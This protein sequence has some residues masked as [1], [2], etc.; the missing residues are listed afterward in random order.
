MLK[1]W[2][3]EK[4]TAL[5]IWWGLDE[6]V[7]SRCHDV[8]IPSRNGTTQIDHLLM[9]RY[10]LFI[11]ET[12]N[13]KGW[14]FGAEDQ[15][16]W[17]QVLYRQ[18]HSFQN[19]LRQTFRQKKVL[20]EFL[21][22]DERFIHT[23]VYFVGDCRFRTKLPSNVL[24]SGLASYVKKFQSQVLT[25]EDL[26]DIRRQLTDLADN[27]PASKKEHLASLRERH[28]SD[29]VCPKCGSKLVERAARN[30]PSAG[31]KFLGCSSYPKCRFTKNID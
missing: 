17:T 19:P 22:I 27:A 13:M 14:I 20:S 4:K 28:S 21:S 7:Y 11:V 1:G 5:A 31:S 26:S 23:V 2:F 18:K 10:G 29:V 12:K 3:G 24:R 6:K 15:A 25:P 8:I 30:G 9:S 16:K